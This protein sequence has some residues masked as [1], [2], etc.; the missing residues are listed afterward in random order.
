MKRLILTLTMVLALTGAQAQVAINATNFPD[1]NFREQVKEAF[2]NIEED[3]IISAEEM[4]A[5]GGHHTFDNVSNLKGIEL[6]TS[7][8]ELYLVN[9]TDEACLRTFDYALPNLNTL[10]IQDQV[11]ELTTVD[12][13]K[14]TN[15]ETFLAGENPASLSTLK[16]PSGIKYLVLNN[17]PLIKTFDPKQFSDLRSVAFT[18]TT[19]ITDL[20]F[21]GHKSIQDIGIDGIHDYYQLNSLNMANCP[22]LT[23]IDIKSSTIKSLTFK[24]L[25]EVLSI[26]VD[27]SDITSML[28][29]DL[30]QL[31]SIEALNNVLGTLT[32]NNLPAITGL[33]CHDNKLQT[34][35]IDKCPNMNGIWAENNKLMWLDLTGVKKAGTDENSLKLNNQYPSVDAYKLS[36]KEVGILVHE[37]F[38]ASRVKNLEAGGVPVPNPTFAEYDGVKY[39][40]VSTDG[41][42]AENLQGWKTTYDYD[43]KWPYAWMEGNSLNN[44]LPV[45]LNVDKLHK[46]DAWMK[47]KTTAFDEPLV[48]EVGGDPLVGANPDTDIEYSKAYIEGEGSVSFASSNKDVVTV[49]PSS[50]ELTVVGPG[51]ATITISGTATYYRNA[52]KSIS[53]QVVIASGGDANGD[54]KT[55]AMDIVAIVNYLMGNPPAGFTVKA[56]DINKDG[57]V[58]AADIVMIVNTILSVN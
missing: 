29:D 43:T 53:Y 56:A 18:G 38:D 55:D 9:Y 37:R 14:C 39:F 47:F 40:V 50:G 51:T 7:I 54:G 19:G 57:K 2:D 31:G 41:A 11:G 6:L 33:D 32:L 10:D 26:L 23:N 36:P 12:A 3:D 58:D 49:D 15:L 1:D 48:G 28:V 35:I 45:N 24:S 8:T 16:L 30:A 20:D 21:S 44:Y 25:P 42:N 4:E 22:L 27:D 52:P 5:N 34:L 13:S 46:L 17:A